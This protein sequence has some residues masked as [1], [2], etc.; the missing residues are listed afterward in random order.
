MCGHRLVNKEQQ[1]HLEQAQQME[2]Q[3]G[4][5]VSIEGFKFG[6]FF[7]TCVIRVDRLSV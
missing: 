1:I 5:S 2:M 3:S 6:E 7:I 4:L